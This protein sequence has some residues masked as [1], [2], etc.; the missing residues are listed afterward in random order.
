MR[1][2]G[3]TAEG[4]RHDH[5]D[6]IPWKL[7]P[8]DRYKLTA[9]I[10]RLLGRARRGDTSIPPEKRGMLIRWLTKRAED[11]KVVTYDYDDGWGLE[12]R[13]P[14]DAELIRPPDDAGPEVWSNPADQK[15]WSLTRIPADQRR[16]M[17]AE[18]QRQMKDQV[19][20]NQILEEIAG[21]Y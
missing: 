20:I 17:I 21:D 3:L 18:R 19:S 5:T 10:L 14:G 9:E 15:I 1:K 7:K 6:T 13:Q 8:E 4:S 2:A 12:P 11:Q 16:A